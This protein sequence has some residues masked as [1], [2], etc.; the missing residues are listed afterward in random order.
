[1]IRVTVLGT[2]ADPVEHVTAPPA[3]ANTPVWQFDHATRE[4][5]PP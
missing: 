1:M 5:N 3:P 4:D 2:I